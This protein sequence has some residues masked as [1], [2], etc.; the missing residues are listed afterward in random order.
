MDDEVR[1][2]ADLHV[3]ARA[4][5][6]AAGIAH[7]AGQPSIAFPRRGKLQDL[8]RRV[9][10]H[11]GR[12]AAQADDDGE[13][14]RRRLQAEAARERLPGKREGAQRG[15]A[16]ALAA[17]DETDIAIEQRP[18]AGEAHACADGH[19]LPVQHLA[20]NRALAQKMDVGDDSLIVEADR[21]SREAPGER[22]EG[23]SRA[24]QERIVHPRESREGLANGVE[25]VILRGVLV[26][27]RKK[28]R[29]GIAGAGRGSRRA[30]RV[31]FQAEADEFIDTIC[32]G[33]DVAEAP[34][35][36]QRHVHIRHGMPRG[37]EHAAHDA[38]GRREPHDDEVVRARQDVQARA[39]EARESDARGGIARQTGVDRALSGRHAGEGEK[40]R[41][42]RSHQRLPTADQHPGDRHA[43]ARLDP[44]MHGRPALQRDVHHARRT[45]R[46]RHVAA[47]APPFAIGGNGHD[48]V[49]AHRNLRGRPESIRPCAHGGD[50][51]F[52]ATAVVASNEHRCLAVR[53]DIV[54]L[55]HAAPQ[56]GARGHCGAEQDGK[57]FQLPRHVERVRDGARFAG[58]RRGLNAESAERH[59]VEAESAARIREHAAPLLAR[60]RVW[61]KIHARAHDGRDAIGGEDLA[62][63]GPASAK[64]QRDRH[65]GSDAR[66]IGFHKVAEQG[67]I[68]ALRGDDGFGQRADGERREQRI[69]NAGL[70]REFE[71]FLPR[72]RIAGSRIHDH[73]DGFGGETR[74]VRRR[75]RIR[76]TREHEVEG[77]CAR[78]VGQR[79]GNADD[80][81]N[82][83][84]ARDLFVI[85]RQRHRHTGREGA[86]GA[87]DLAVHCHALVKNRVHDLR[88]IGERMTARIGHSGDRHRARHDR[89][90]RLPHVEQRHA[91]TG[92]N[93]HRIRRIAVVE[94][95]G[96]R[97]V[98]AGLLHRLREKN[99]EHRAVVP[100]LQQRSG[101]G[102][103]ARFHTRI[104]RHRDETRRGLGDQCRRADQRLINHPVAL[105][106]ELQLGRGAADDI[107]ETGTRRKVRHIPAD[108]CPL[109]IGIGQQDLNRSQRHRR[110][111]RPLKNQTVHALRHGDMP[112]GTP[113]SRSPGG[114]AGVER[115]RPVARLHGN[116][117]VRG[118]RRAPRPALPSSSEIRRPRHQPR[119][120]IEC[121]GELD[122][123]LKRLAPFPTGIG[124]AEDLVE[125]FVEAPRALPVE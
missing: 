32:I 100:D 35:L 123:V 103:P 75:N 94:H 77:K 13:K 28:L 114:A 93:A 110:L 8:I 74:G 23:R 4:H 82:D 16:V 69:L 51:V 34:Q 60:R 88:G 90:D 1:A 25:D 57:I 64:P 14:R 99:G 6:R 97:A 61:E 53:C 111:R 33:G 19:A 7:Q 45:A 29:V 84:V 2:E 38:P 54:V 20:G 43:G 42:I 48:V 101:L 22:I 85:D 12:A 9:R 115:H 125:A 52:E 3:H 76:Q 39:A 10:I 108:G 50:D 56:I 120:P 92:L 63:D 65:G 17:D 112:A 62:R 121:I 44:A 30:E 72:E 40:S 113:V 41:G 109:P 24:I 104:L 37:I 55:R 5:R 73:L 21:G 67:A 86:V 96:I 106:I 117:K 124:R 105:Q 122:F 83:A 27:E 46:R 95:V 107:L 18:H 116:E 78:R 118:R 68:E 80:E 70:A 81:R 98:H 89:A 31:G 26:G 119:R 87:H 71:Q 91:P 15:I 36:G 66:R 59:T 79:L 11:A 49:G 47:L 58:L 102:R